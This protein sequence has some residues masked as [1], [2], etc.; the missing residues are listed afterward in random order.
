MSTPTA[1][2]PRTERERLAR[3]AELRQDRA[4]GSS[5]I[6][7]AVGRRDLARA[8][9]DRRRAAEAAPESM[10]LCVTR[11]CTTEPTKPSSADWSTPS[12]PPLIRSTTSLLA[13]C[14]SD[15][16]AILCDAAQ[17]LGRRESARSVPELQRLTEHADDNVAL[18]AVEALGRIGGREALGRSARPS[19]ES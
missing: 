16:P 17:I 11:W 5:R 6:D 1:I 9:G 15:S 4:S 14:E 19:R 2:T 8:P 7:P 18:A 13:L 10:P 12:R 3:V